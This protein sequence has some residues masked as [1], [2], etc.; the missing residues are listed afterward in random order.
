[1][2]SASWLIEMLSELHEKFT[3][4]NGAD[5]IPSL[6]DGFASVSPAVSTTS[7][8]QRG[9]NQ[10]LTMSKMRPPPTI[11]EILIDIDIAL[12]GLIPRNP[13]PPLWLWRQNL[14]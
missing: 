8:T 1:M 13:F 4:I 3:K 7:L 6:Y 5:L 2:G 11:Y 10:H 14:Q 12:L 9:I